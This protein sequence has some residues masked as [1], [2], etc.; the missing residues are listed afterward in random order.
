M[1]KF[2]AKKL[3]QNAPTEIKAHSS[4]YQPKEKELIIKPNIQ[5]K[6]SK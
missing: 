6:F 1:L 5:R 3:D 4:E 2:L